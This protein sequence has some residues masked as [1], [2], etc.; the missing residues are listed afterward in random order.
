MPPRQ[1]QTRWKRDVEGEALRLLFQSGDANPE[2]TTPDYINSVRTANLQQFSNI[3]GRNFI[4]NYRRYAAEC[5][6]ERDMAGA[7]RAA[8]AARAL[9]E[10]R[11]I[12]PVVDVLPCLR[13]KP[14][15]V[16]V[17]SMRVR[18]S[19][20]LLLYVLSS[21]THSFSLCLDL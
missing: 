2:D 9:L 8:A 20:M 15:L 12:R 3:T 14:L 11:R 5:L 6:T 1:R 19:V 16:V 4:T 17:V 21:F 18:T 13:S 7:R 10:Q